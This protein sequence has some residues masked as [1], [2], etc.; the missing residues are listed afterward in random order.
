ML[1][2]ADDLA[3]GDHERVTGVQRP[4]AVAEADAASAVL[5]VGEHEELVRM[6][7]I[8]GRVGGREFVGGEAQHADRWGAGSSEVFVDR[9]AV[10]RPPG[11]PGR[12]SGN[13]RS[14]YFCQGIALSYRRAI[15]Y[16]S[17]AAPN[18]FVLRGTR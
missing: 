9:G 2:E 7:V 14:L 12:L 11:Q 10:D 1:A 17:L 15:N 4:L 18:I 6:G 8:A 16:Y 13:Q 5:E 3:W